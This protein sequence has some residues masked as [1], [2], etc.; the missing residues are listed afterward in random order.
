MAST[1]ILCAK[2]SNRSTTLKPKPHRFHFIFRFLFQLIVHYNPNPYIYLSIYIYIDVCIYTDILTSD[3]TS[4][5]GDM[6]ISSKGVAG[7]QSYLRV[8]IGNMGIMEKE[9]E[10]TGIMVV[11][12][13]L[14][15]VI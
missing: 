5:S 11:L 7:T 1:L 12:Q 10:T 3:P 4:D 13:G 15:R 8:N 2:L 9:T 6:K 14:N